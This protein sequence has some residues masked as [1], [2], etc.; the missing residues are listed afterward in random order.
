MQVSKNKFRINWYSAIKIE[1]T[2]TL[3]EELQPVIMENKSPKVKIN[4]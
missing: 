1:S 2:Y 3:I 4:R